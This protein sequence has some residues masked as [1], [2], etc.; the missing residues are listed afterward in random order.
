MKILSRR[1]ILS[2]LGLVGAGAAVMRWQEKS[3][4]EQNMI[5]QQFTL[6]F[7]WQTQE[8]F[9]FCVHH[10]DFYPKGNPNFGPDK[11]L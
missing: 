2:A 9:L 11:A 7:Q 6:D 1:L 10:Y 3:E 4:Q 8:P 5:K